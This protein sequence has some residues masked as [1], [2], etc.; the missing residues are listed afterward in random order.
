M[1]QRPAARVAACRRRRRLGLLGRV[2][3]LHLL[4]LL[5]QLATLVLGHRLVLSACGGN[6][7]RRRRWV[8]VMVACGEGGDRGWRRGMAVM[9][10]VTSSFTGQGSGDGGG[11]PAWQRR[12]CGRRSRT[13]ILMLDMVEEAE[14]VVGGVSAEGWQAGRRSEQTRSKNAQFVT[15]F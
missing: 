13:S 14:A 2:V 8:A 9:S 6:G 10:R 5:E 7:G 1:E 12:G 4:D 3:H 15:L 11:G